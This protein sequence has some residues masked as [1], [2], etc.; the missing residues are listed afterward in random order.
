MAT[1]VKENPRKFTGRTAVCI[2]QVVHCTTPAEGCDISHCYLGNR[3]LPKV[4][5][6]LA[7]VMKPHIFLPEHHT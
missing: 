1:E 3:D 4:T 2:V 7:S 5:V 6:L